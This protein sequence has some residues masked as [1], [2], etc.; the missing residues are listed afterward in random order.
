[1]D[2]LYRQ[3]VA[4][5]ILGAVVFLCLIFLPA[6]T[7]NYWQGWL[8]FG[9]F[10]ASTTSLTIYLARHDRP[11]LERR[12]KAGPQHE[13]EWSQ[14]IKLVVDRPDCARRAGAPVAVA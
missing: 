5:S 8:F 10:A 9:A 14:K 6:W 3:V 13:Q 1:M 2:P 11:L 12:L 4:Q 7:L